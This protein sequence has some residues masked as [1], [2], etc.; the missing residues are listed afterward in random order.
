[1]QWPLYTAHYTIYIIYFTVYSNPTQ[2]TVYRNPCTSCRGSG[3][4]RRQGSWQKLP[5]DT[6]ALTPPLLAE[7]WGEKLCCLSFWT[8]A[9][10]SFLVGFILWPASSLDY[11]IVC[12]ALLEYICCGVCLHLCLSVCLCHSGLGRSRTCLLFDELG[13]VECLGVVSGCW[14]SFRLLA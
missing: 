9:S 10:P 11:S 14:R 8:S 12:F 1:M 5:T 2:Y 3:G 13:V 7:F 4:G 6:S